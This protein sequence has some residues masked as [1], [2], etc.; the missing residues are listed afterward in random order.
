M[1]N[2]RGCLC[3]CCWTCLPSRNLTSKCTR[4][5]GTVL[6]AISSISS[7]QV[8]LKRFILDSSDLGGCPL[9]S[10]KA[11]RQ[12]GGLQGPAWHPGVVAQARGS[13][14]GSSQ[15]LSTIQVLLLAAVVRACVHYVVQVLP[16]EIINMKAALFGFFMMSG[17]T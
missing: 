17:L 14:K 7:A 11:G 5:W 12:A 8:I 3:A 1:P 9:T 2:S 4:G 13:V 10:H 15:E 16:E 6:E